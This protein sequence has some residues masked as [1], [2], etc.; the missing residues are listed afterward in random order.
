MAED[1]EGGPGPGPAAP[2]NTTVQVA[3]RCRPM[4]E[5]EF[6]EGGEECVDIGKDGQTVTLNAEGGSH[7]FAFDHVFGKNSTQP[8]VFETLGNPLLDK[9]FEGYNATIFAYGQTGS[10]KTHTMMADRKSDDKGLIPRI[11]EQ[12]FERIGNLTTATRKFLVCCSFLEIYNEIVYDLLVPRGKS[13]PKTGLEIR[14]QKGIGVYVKDLQEIVVENSE[15]LQKLIDQ[16]FEHRATASTNMNA[17]SSR[18]HCLF[19]IKMHQKDEQNTAN[20]NFSKMN[21]VDLAGSERASRTGAQGDTLKEGANINKSL[22]SLGNVINALSKMAAGGKKG[23]IPYRD[24]KLTRVLQ[25]SLGGNALTT[26]MAALSPAKINAEETLSTLNYAKRAKTI[27][28]NATKNEESEQIARLEEEVQALREKLAQQAVGTVDTSKYENQIEDMEKFMKQTWADKEQATRHH[29]EER[30]ALEQEANKNRER[31][32]AERDR[33][34]K[35]LEEKG[36]LEMTVQ[37]LRAHGENVGSWTSCSSSWTSQV[38]RILMLEQKVAS[39]CRAVLHCKDAVLQDVDSWCDQHTGEDEDKAGVASR[40]LLNQA[41][42]K[43]STMLVELDALENEEN[44]LH[45]CIVVLL[46]EVKRMLSGME[47]EKETAKKQLKEGE[48]ADEDDAIGGPMHEEIQKVLSLFYKQLVGHQAYVWGRVAEDHRDLNKLRDGVNKLLAQSEQLGVDVDAFRRQLEEVSPKPGQELTNGQV[49][50]AQN[51]GAEAAAALESPLGLSDGRLQDAA[52]SASSNSHV[53]AAGR[54]LGGLMANTYSGWC[55]DTADTAQYLQVDLGAPHWIY[56]LST[57]GRHPASGDWWLTRPLVVQILE[58]DLMPPAR[59]FKRPPVRLIHDVV[60]AACTKQNALQGQSGKADF[61]ESQLDYKKLANRQD[62][63]DFFELLIEK[64]NSTL[65][66]VGLTAEDSINLTANDILGGKNTLESNR[67]LQVLCYVALQKKVAGKTGGLLMCTPQWVSTYRVFW[68]NDASQWTPLRHLGSQEAA[69]FS[70]N[71][72][73]SEVRYCCFGSSQPPEPARYLRV[74]P[75]EWSAWPGMRLEVFGWSPDANVATLQAANQPKKGRGTS[76]SLTEVSCQLAVVR[77]QA[78]WAK[79]AVK[80]ISVA[81]TTKW[82]E[83]QAAEA[84]KNQQAVNEKSQVEQ[85]LLHAQK[86]LEELRKTNDILEEK[87]AGAEQKLVD[88]GKLEADTLR[89]QSEVTSLEE[90]VKE[91]SESLQEEQSKVQEYE[92]K[93]A[94]DKNTIEEMQ[95]QI[96]VLTEERNDARAKEE[97]NYENLQARDE[98]L[99]NTNEGYCRLSEQ[100][101]EAKDELNNE[102]EK[103]NKVIDSLTQEKKTMLD[104]RIELQNAIKQLKQENTRLEKEKAH[105]RDLKASL[106]HGTNGN[107]N[108]NGKVEDSAY[109]AAG[110]LKKKKLSGEGTGN[111]SEYAEDWEDE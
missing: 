23:F 83:I 88:L 11:S 107:G 32:L 98:E 20:N 22:S 31:A 52:I 110:T 73:G 72:D 12:L 69:V 45:E 38:G 7:T 58:T 40:M 44:K 93:A 43:T 46:P 101:N 97:E 109:P 1:F 75:V 105:W 106:S 87:F 29:E 25:E 76:T 80:S 8:Q 81:A 54:L 82:K 108:M 94:D 21:L 16:G 95:M 68:S 56:A 4:S 100:L 63:V 6:K 90:K 99:Y 26:M 79:Q 96:A 103:C 78:E 102:V 50:A 14:E 30:R 27:K 42:R 111:D 28:V 49:G 89:L 55:P 19:I 41:E 15:K 61:N 64:V 9:A 33:R 77:R 2:G 84:E 5:K 35:L 85:Q 62:K 3:I 39:Q 66:D 17:T 67:L 36:D 74:C 53:A 60:V 51:I 13:T 37:E 86:E 18:S 70:G 71:S 24:S 91:K 59:V 104:E 47:A 92:T 48:K 10:G 65:S 34:V 57:Q